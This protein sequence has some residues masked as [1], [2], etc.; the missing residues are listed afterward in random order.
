MLSRARR[1]FLRAYSVRIAW[2]GLVSPRAVYSPSVYNRLK[3]DF[4]HTLYSLRDVERRPVLLSAAQYFALLSARTKVTDCTP[5]YV[6]EDLLRVRFDVRLGL[7]VPGFQSAGYHT[8]PPSEL[9]TEPSDR[10]LDQDRGRG[11]EL[12]VARRQLLPDLHHRL[13]KVRVAKVALECSRA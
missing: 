10:L 2:L 7:R 4:R 3:A 5:P 6:R 8:K 11:W 1:R 13:E 9:P 12:D